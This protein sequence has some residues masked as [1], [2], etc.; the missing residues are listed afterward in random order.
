[1]TMIAYPPKPSPG[2]RV[3]VISP[4]SGL[5]GL[6]PLPHELGLRR[7]REE[8][9]LEPVEYPATRTM[10]STPAARAADVHAAFADP[11]IKAV[12]ASIGGDDQITVLPLLDRELIRANPK[13]FFGLSDNTNLLA[14]LRNTGI[15]GY[16]GASVMVELGRPGAMHPQTADSL[17]A[18]LFTSG[19]YELRPAERF[20]DVDRDW[21]DP[22][23]FDREPP[24]RPGSGWSW[25]N[26]DR[27]V[28]GRTWGG[29]L[30]IL[31]WLL[32]ADR[33][34]ARD[35]AE[36]D[37]GVLLLETSEELPSAEEVFRTLRNMGERGLL[38]RFSALLMA[39]PKT[40]SFACPNSPEEG[41]RYAAEQREAVLR[42]MRVYAP[43]ATIVF[44]VDF[45]HTDPQ[46]VIPY[47]GTVRVD[48]P[49]R[50]VTVTY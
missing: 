29:C 22:A 11:S 9:G 13:P 30:E 4:S 47:G 49:A 44:D 19:P 16:H 14:Y 37:G 10:D 12:I 48:G 41:V 6:F 43:E 31:G 28:E 1:M 8:F 3:A 24:S 26:A 25:V 27:V 5:P 23:T 42:A 36:Y 40:W 18:A 50:R 17:R 46:V 20:N 32:M 39:R 2:D 33:E 7:L 34:I 21:A 45:G 35:P 38:G 15:V